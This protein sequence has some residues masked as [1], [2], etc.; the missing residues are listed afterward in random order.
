M[1]KRNELISL[2]KQIIALRFQNELG[3]QNFQEENK[4]VFEPVTVSNKVVSEDVIKTTE[5]TSK[6]TDKALA[7]LNNK[8]WDLLT[9]RG[10]LGS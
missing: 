7:S 8:H 3:K 5:E 4:K 10:V 9:D 6:G 2:Q 1:K